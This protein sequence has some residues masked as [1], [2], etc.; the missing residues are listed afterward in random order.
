MANQRKATKT[1]GRLTFGRELVSLAALLFLIVAGAW[2]QQKNVASLGAVNQG[3]QV[4][5]TGAPPTATP[6]GTGSHSL[7]L[8]VGRSLVISS[9]TPIK[10]VSI[11]DPNIAEAVVVSPYQ[12]LLNGK[13]PG[14]V[15]LLVWD[16]MDQSQ[17]FEVSVDI[18]VLS[19]NEKIHEVFPAEAVQLETSKDVVMLSGKISSVLVAAQI[20]DIVKGSTP[21]VI[22]LMTFPPTPVKEILLEVKFAEVDRI[23]VSQ[24][25]VN[26]LRQFGSNMPFSTSTQQFS[27]PSFQNPT[28]AQTTANGTTTGA[29]PA[30]FNVNNLLNMAIFRPDINMGV[31]IEALQANNVLQ[32]LAEPNL[33]TESG[34]QA[35]F[36]AGGEFPVPVVQ[37][38]VAGGVAPVTIQFKEFGVRL[39]FIPTLMPDGLI[40]LNVKPE[41]SSLDYTNAITI[42]GTTVPAL[43][44]RRAESDMELKD[45]QSFAIAGLIDNQ[46]TEQMNKIPG[47]SSLP[48]LGK[49]FQSRSLSKSKDELL[50]V[51]TPRIVQPLNPENVP[52][53][54]VFPR[55][56]LGPATPAPAEHEAAPKAN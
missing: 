3:T 33:L 55:S 56:F 8:L 41:V 21:K 4:P 49:L 6:E 16:E 24:L 38:S 14:G 29:T 39:T 17:S 9:P 7:H 15:S 18:D 11:A 26:I 46:V 5:Q 37:G 36:L 43:S 20:L 34:K 35:S 23:A 53:G 48:I 50:I 32:I 25:G 31:L 51:V 42:S 27:P 10:R 19:L 1:T 52:A 30:Q 45:G 13:A 28:P 22:S 47:I 44:T 12:L 40:H 54:P 2:A